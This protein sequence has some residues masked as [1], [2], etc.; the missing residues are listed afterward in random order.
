MLVNQ[1]T[2]YYLRTMTRP[3]LC[4]DFANT[5]YWRGQA[6][7]TETL[8][9][10]ADLAAWTKAPKTPSAKEFEQ[11]QFDLAVPCVEPRFPP[12][13]QSPRTERAQSAS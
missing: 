10:P 5:R 2:G 11:V 8:H 13:E 9:A 1:S 12:I 4:L 6:A 7:P 3:D